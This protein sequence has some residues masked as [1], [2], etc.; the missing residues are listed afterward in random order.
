MKKIYIEHL[1]IY[2]FSFIWC[3]TLSLFF[4]NPF[5]FPPISNYT[6]FVLIC[7]ISM[8][9]I[10]F[11]SGKI[12]SNDFNINIHSVYNNE[13]ELHFPVNL[14]SKLILIFTSFSLLGILLK[15]YIVMNAMGGFYEYIMMPSETRDFILQIGFGEGP[16][17]PI[18]YKIVSYMGSLI[19]ACVVVGGTIYTFPKKKLISVYPLFV[20]LI[21]SIVEFKRSSFV[22]NYIYWLI[23]AFVFIYYQPLKIQ[24]KNIK[25][26][27][28]QLIAF[29]IILVVFSL[30]IL[31]MRY[32][33]Y[34]TSFKNVLINSFYF[35]IAGNI[36]FLDKFL[37]TDPEL[38]YGLS[39][40]RSIVSWF[41]RFGLMEKSKVL[42][43]HYGFY[44][45][46]SVSM[47]T[48]TYIR[49][50]YED[51]GLIGVV[52]ISYIW[53][54]ISYLVMKLYLNRFTFVRVGLVAI[55]V[56]TLIWSFYGFNLVYITSYI[57]RIIQL[58]LLDFYLLIL[59]IKEI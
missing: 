40:F 29:T 22:A 55:I 49:V 35:Y 4:L 44:T 34:T 15:T 20:S 12:L 24:K 41:S 18:T 53:G 48:F 59:K 58:A 9:F 31:L 13:K 56:F 23:S 38:L 30:S 54:I 33:Y 28:K 52:F 37:S 51:F 25:S 19:F 36:W 47:N 16:V 26:L 6:W 7:G 32:Y 45:I 21:Y 43:H 11:F 3:V 5:D 10:G 39:L 46:K 57:W 8:V 14:I 2:V 27:F 1:P 17:N 42:M 50:L